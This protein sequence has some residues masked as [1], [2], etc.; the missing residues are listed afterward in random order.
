MEQ[1]NQGTGR[2]VKRWLL[3]VGVF[4][5]TQIVFILLDGTGYE[6]KINDS[7]N[8]FASMARSILDSKLFTEWISIYSY[9]FFNLF[10]TVFVTAIII[11]AVCDIVLHRNSNE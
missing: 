2:M 5:V 8:L 9:P 4:I 11:Q 6:P 3:I 7:D 10:L 1:A